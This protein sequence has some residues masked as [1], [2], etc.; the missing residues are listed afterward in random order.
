MRS[1][2]SRLPSSKVARLVWDYRLLVS[3]A[4]AVLLLLALYTFFVTAG[5]WATWPETSRYYDQLAS[6]FQSGHL[7]LDVQAPDSLRSLPDPYDPQARNSIPALKAFVDQVWDASFYDGK[8]YLYWGPVPAL[9]LWI[10]KLLGYPLIGDQYLVFAFLG[11]LLTF[12]SLFLIRLAQRFYKDEPA[13]LIVV[14]VLVAALACPI[15]W[16]LSRPAIYEAAIAAGQ[17]FLIGGLYFAF[18]ALDRETPSRLRLLLAAFFWALAAGSRLPTILPAAFLIIATFVWLIRSNGAKNKIRE[19]APNLLALGLPFGLGVLCLGWYNWARF[20]SVF[21]TGLRYALT[22][23]NLD[24]FHSESFSLSYVLPNLWFFLLNPISIRST[25]PFMALTYGH[26]PSFLDP[27]GSHIFHLEEIAGLMFVAPF[28]LFSVVPVIKTISWGSTK[29]VGKPSREQSSQDRLLLWIS[30]CLIGSSI[31]SFATLLLYFYVAMRL[32]ADFVPSLLLLS[33]LG[34]LESYHCVR[35]GSRGHHLY[36]FS[37]IILAGVSIAASTILT[38]A[39]NYNR[40][41]HLNP[42]LFRSILRFFTR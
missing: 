23:T 17:F 25:F 37:A 19:A 27:S 35:Q 28:V 12:T 16:M 38:I 31:L 32:L 2:L 10:A 15:P 21:E 20:G 6:A 36:A 33:A 39:S 40:F 7:Y 1:T 5:N 24:K 14:C 13:S 11:G 42:H 41:Q 3:T 18:S 34:V 8:F 26:S 29:H 30:V 9:C 22:F 4:I